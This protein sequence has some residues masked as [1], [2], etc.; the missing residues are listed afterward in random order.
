MSTIAELGAFLE[1]ESKAAH[2]LPAAPNIDTL[3]KRRA[4]A[5]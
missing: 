4:G 2:D 5:P 3:D 1:R